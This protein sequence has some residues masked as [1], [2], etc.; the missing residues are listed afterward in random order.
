M[1]YL[2]HILKKFS[3]NRETHFLCSRL[4]AMLSIHPCFWRDH[5]CQ[6]AN[7]STVLAQLS[8]TGATSWTLSFN[9]IPYSVNHMAKAFSIL[10]LLYCVSPVSPVN[11]LVDCHSS[12]GPL[13][14]MGHCTLWNELYFMSSPGKNQTRAQSP[15]LDC[16]LSISLLQQFTRSLTYKVTEPHTYKQKSCLAKDEG[17]HLSSSLSL[18]VFP[19]SPQE[20]WLLVDPIPKAFWDKL[21]YTC[22][23]AWK[24]GLHLSCGLLLIRNY[25]A[26]T[27][28]RLQGQQL[29]PLSGHSIQGAGCFFCSHMVLLPTQAGL[30]RSCALGQP[31]AGA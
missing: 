23:P 16:Q 19:L 7:L 10:L 2:W 15:T 30:C 13:K 8:V 26:I 29:L 12:L 31:W 9:A 1:T 6:D 21:V 18:Q 14:F 4:A 20:S 27:F 5:M 17:A 28:V 3:P 25:Q 11:Y 22:L 24:S